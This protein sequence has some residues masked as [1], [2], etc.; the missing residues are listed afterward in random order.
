MPRP[1]RI[2]YPDAWY[3][4]MNRGR[5]GDEIFTEAKDYVA[6]IALLKE[7]IED[8][9]VKVAAYCLM[10]NHYHLLVQTP[11]SNISRA[12]RH[13]NGVYTQRYN[14]IH[15]CDGQLFRGRYKAILVEANSYLLE[16]LRYIHR[17]PLE[18]NLVD[19][20][21]KYNWSSHKGYASKDNKW[22][23]L[24]K[25]FALTLFSKDHTESIKLYKQFVSQQVPDEI[26]TMLGRRKL[27]SVMGTKQF[28]YKVK[29]LFFSD[30][31]HEEIPEAKI[32]APDPD[33]IL[34][35]VSKFYNIGMDDLMRSRRGY[36]NEPRNVAI[37][38]MRRLRGDTLKV[39]GEVFGINKNSTVSSSVHRVKYEMRRGRSIRLRIEELI[40]ILSNS[41]TET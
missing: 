28:I 18:A 29:H 34:G 26:T 25:E 5:R 37:Y 14:R 4:V 1:L 3:H 40:K 39:V 2:Q 38:L 31:S 17:N 22:D 32:L 12:M 23:W 16:L 21:H 35:A 33:R 8:Y 6:F 20:L 9:N 41:Q 11:D 13:L 19:N 24:Y 15:H 36:F 10:P 30:K 27:P 7:T